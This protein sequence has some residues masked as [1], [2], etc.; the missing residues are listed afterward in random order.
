M[1]HDPDGSRLPIKLDTTTNGEFAPIP[2]ARVHHEAN[3]IALED[4]TRHAKALGVTRR[5]FMVSACGAA[6]TLLAMNRAYARSGER[7]S[8]YDL[9][10]DAARDELVARSKL[11]TGEFIFDVQGHFVNPTGAWTKALPQ[12]AQPLRSFAGNKQCAAVSR[13]GLD[14]LECLNG[15]AFIK[16]VFHDSDTDVCVL[17]FVP[18]TR[19]GEPLTIEE[20]AATARIVERMEGTH[21]LLLHGRVNPNQDGDLESMDM[22]AEKYRVA[23]W[24]TYT[25]WGPDGKGFFLDDD[26][27][28]AFIEKARKLGVR[29]I[30]VHKGL[31]FGQRSYEH[32]TCADIGRVAR[33]FP[34][35][36]FLIYHS[37]FVAGKPEGPYDASRTDGID[38]LVK[39]LQEN[40]V[41][42]GSNV[43][44]ELGSTWRFLMR[45]P[46]AAAHGVGKLLKHVGEDNVLW[47]TDS[48]W[49][50]SPQDQI[51]A[52]RAFT[53]AEGIRERHGYPGMTPAL[54]A[55]VFGRN[56]LRI[57]ALPDDVV[58]KH[59]PRDRVALDREAYREAADPDFLTHGPRTRREFLTLRAWST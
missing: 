55:K 44:A 33:R 6:S 24:K 57:Y 48:I 19:K 45:D 35:V 10:A 23:A 7:A 36:N 46:D 14:Y 29:N 52:F 21:R 37:G 22:L 54:R 18:S 2:L 43:Y 9:P 8:F 5:R 39:S 49:Y 26:V 1:A 59:L 53:I 31:P 47:G 51:Q 32:S 3:A 41:A 11:D 17:S 38:G 25:Q 28:L 4:A 42:P 15:D 27:G 13:P 12:G 30:A 16:D 34:D 20:A 58:K 40:D 50:G 56:A